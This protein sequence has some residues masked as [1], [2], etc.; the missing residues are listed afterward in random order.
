MSY[1][2][3]PT[4]EEEEKENI[5]SGCFLLYREK[6]EIGCPHDVHIFL[7]GN[8]PFLDRKVST[9]KRWIEKERPDL[10]MAA[11]PVPL[12]AMYDQPDFYKLQ[13]RRCENGNSELAGKLYP[14][15]LPSLFAN[16]K[17]KYFYQGRINGLIKTCNPKRCDDNVFLRLVGKNDKIYALRNSLESCIYHREGVKIF[18]PQ[19]FKCPFERSTAFF[20]R[21]NVDC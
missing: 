13:V 21:P 8:E 20:M 4:E 5:V 6:E 10:V 19:K 2:Y 11:A 17:S 3:G 1:Y 12:Y 9:A 15:N 18:V 16:P 14:V 7:V